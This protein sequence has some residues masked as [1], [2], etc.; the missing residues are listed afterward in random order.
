MR[1]RNVQFWCAALML[2]LC[3]LPRVSR[4]QEVEP[5]V[6]KGIWMSKNE[7]LALPM[8]GAA[9][10]RVKAV[11]DQPAG[12]PDLAN[13][14]DSVNVKVMAKALVYART[15]VKSYRKEVIAACMA[16]MGTEQGGRTL[17]LG[18]ELV[19]YVIAAD[20]VGLPAQE[21]RVYRKWLR[22]C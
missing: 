2:L 19:A 8:S 17:A 5:R 16:A 4:A 9:W 20:L 7:L 1:R 11:A 12:P 21:K 13:Q 18:R 14:N 22:G 10:E 3:V 6:R 15:G